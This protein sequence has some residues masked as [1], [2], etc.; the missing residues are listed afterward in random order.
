MKSDEKNEIRVVKVPVS[1]CDKTLIPII[2]REGTQW[3]VS[4]QEHF[5]SCGGSFLLGNILF[6]R[7]LEVSPEDFDVFFKEAA[8]YFNFMHECIKNN[9]KTFISAVEVHNKT[10]E[11]MEN[12]VKKLTNLNRFEL[13]EWY[14]Q[15]YSHKISKTYDEI[16]N[17][18][19]ACFSRIKQ[20]SESV[21]IQEFIDSLI[22]FEYLIEVHSK[23]ALG[24]E[25]LK[26][27]NMINSINQML[28][29]ID[30]QESI[31]KEKLSRKNIIRT[32]T[33]VESEG[34]ATW[35]ELKVLEAQFKIYQCQNFLSDLKE[36]ENYYNNLD[37]SHP[38]RKGLEIYRNIEK[39]FGFVCAHLSKVVS[40]DISIA[41]K[42]KIDSR[43][44]SSKE[45][46]QFFEKPINNPNFRITVIGS[47]TKDYNGNNTEKFIEYTKAK[48]TDESKRYM[49]CDLW[50]NLM[51]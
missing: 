33:V 15:N 26:I 5:D 28:H 29:K 49:K 20:L 25:S 43:M 32:A 8:P 27:Q 17:E 1:L 4:L 47:L 36:R 31:D 21:D 9:Q 48:I 34:Y 50:G 22:K 30:V 3:W 38:N 7:T 24:S 46:K 40:Y 18:I 14:R 45:L 35:D 2:N 23:N 16:E 11:Y 39:T 19:N 41:D 10:N 37:I 6:K 12:E 44:Y 51:E 13:W 42:T